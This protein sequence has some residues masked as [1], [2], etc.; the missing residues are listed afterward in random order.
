MSPFGLISV[1]FGSALVVAALL[2][3]DYQLLLAGC[4]IGVIF[5]SAIWQTRAARR[6]QPFDPDR[7]RKRKL[8]AGTLSFPTGHVQACDDWHAQRTISLHV[9]PGDYGLS[10]T[11]LVDGE[12]AVIERVVL[13]SAAGIH[14]ASV[15]SSQTLAVDTGFIAIA[16]ASFIEKHW[17]AEDVE[18]RVLA[19]M[20]SG[21]GQ[22]ASHF[23]LMA[24]GV[25]YGVVLLAEDDV[26]TFRVS[27]TKAHG[28]QIAARVY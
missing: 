14:D 12:Q 20:E 28:V 15:K 18:R 10:F 19:M 24:E 9:P 17:D 2:F 6:G 3:K 21:S 23:L 13:R 16:D 4:G 22:G 25:S 1:A 26:H 11:L 7:A 8:D 27:D 5:V